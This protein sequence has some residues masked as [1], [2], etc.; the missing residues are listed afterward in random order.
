[1]EQLILSIEE[2]Q[3]SYNFNEL[4]KFVGIQGYLANVIYADV[5]AI[6]TWYF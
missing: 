1:M 4:S 3:L 6:S 2:N 5:N